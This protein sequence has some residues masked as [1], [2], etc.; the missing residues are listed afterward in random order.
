MTATEGLAQAV[1][2]GSLDAVTALLKA[3]AEVN[4]GSSPSLV[5]QAVSS[6]KAGLILEALIEAGADVDSR[7]G[8]GRTPLHCAAEYWP[9]AGVLG[10]LVV[11]GADVNARDRD[12]LTPLHWAAKG[13]P[14]SPRVIKDLVL[15][16]ATV[17][18]RDKNGLTP[19][20]WALRWR[21][22][23][24]AIAPL[25]AHGAAVD[26][27]DG[28][29]RTPL[30]YAAMADGR[31]GEAVF[32][33][34]AAGAEM[35]ARDQ[36]DRT[37]LH[38]A[39]DN[40]HPEAVLA[41]IEAEADAYAQDAEKQTP[42]HRAVS[43]N[44]GTPEVAAHLVKWM[45]GFGLDLRDSNGNT[46]LH[47]TAAIRDNPSSASHLRQLRKIGSGEKDVELAKI[48]IKAGADLDARNHRGETPRD[49][50]RRSGAVAVAD[51]LL[52]AWQAASEVGPWFS[53]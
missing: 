37:P 22:N 14:N 31:N 50:A 49:V 29:G 45:F 28:T 5:H 47:L 27:R 48:L 36:D 39:A 25:I 40:Y 43:S 42:L 18:A 30:H 11:A 21:P 32:A 23:M 20:H 24:A 51:L 52:E 1:R 3:G 41:L 19:L 33:L 44:F 4:D 13:N 15:E 2:A 12:G 10:P 17:N 38:Y 7:D 16:G 6:D 53:V 34:L 9:V 8:A 35:A 46:A 26:G